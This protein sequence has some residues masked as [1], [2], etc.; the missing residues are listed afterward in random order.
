MRE[1]NPT[2]ALLAYVDQFPFQ[3]DAAKALKI[4]PAYLS[5]LVNGRR[6][7]TDPLLA[8]LGLRRVV[9]KAEKGA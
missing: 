3:R 7:I 6:D 1:T 5:D 4:S 2:D 8:K 9:I